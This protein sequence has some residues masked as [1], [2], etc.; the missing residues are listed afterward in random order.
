MPKLSTLESEQNYC[1]DCGNLIDED[2]EECA[3]CG[4]F[5]FGAVG[6]DLLSIW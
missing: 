5:F 4:V 1:P 2:C 6:L 3:V